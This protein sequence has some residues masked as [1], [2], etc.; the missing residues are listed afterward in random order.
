MDAEREEQRRREGDGKRREWQV[1]D[2]PIK[3]LLIPSNVRRCF[4][5]S[6][7]GLRMHLLRKWNLSSAVSID[8]SREPR[9]RGKRMRS[10][11]DVLN[12]LEDRDAQTQRRRKTFWKKKKQKHFCVASRIYLRRTVVSG[13]WCGHK[14]GETKIIGDLFKWMFIVATSNIAHYQT[15][16]VVQSKRDFRRWPVAQSAYHCLTPSVSA[17]DHSVFSKLF[18]SIDNCCYPRS[19]DIYRLVSKMS[20]AHYANAIK[21]EFVWYFPRSDVRTVG[22]MGDPN[23]FHLGI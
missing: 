12:Y 17:T 4:S 19:G 3:Y 11:I 15:R 22:L 6:F 18:V 16:S 14:R 20:L 5:S 2:I 21:A 1:R 13:R 23:G 10:A 7:F 8:R 9:S